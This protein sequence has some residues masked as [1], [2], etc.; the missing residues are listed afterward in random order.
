[1]YNEKYPSLQWKYFHV[2]STVIFS[3]L[4]LLMQR[5]KLQNNVC[6]PF[7]LPKSWIVWAVSP[8]VPEVSPHF[9]AP[10]ADQ[11]SI[12]GGASQEVLPGDSCY[13]SH[14]GRFFGRGNAQHVS[15]SPSFWQVNSFLIFLMGLFQHSFIEHCVSEF[16]PSFWDLLNSQIERRFSGKHPAFGC[17]V[18][19]S[20]HA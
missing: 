19:F 6:F 7:C 3:E 14:A 13:L 18:F 15:A 10:C 20:V 4:S 2:L 1:M 11:H 16:V 17:P 9:G 5:G 12:W 8:H